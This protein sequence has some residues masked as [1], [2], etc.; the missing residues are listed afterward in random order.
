M[1][2]LMLLLV[3]AMVV[4]GCNG[5]QSVEEL[6]VTGKPEILT[7]N[8]EVP[9]ETPFYP[10]V[11]MSPFKGF[12]A[13]TNASSIA[14]LKNDPK[15]YCF[16]LNKGSI[17]W[18]KSIEFGYHGRLEYSGL[19]DKVFVRLDGKLTCLDLFTGD[20][21]WQSREQIDWI[22]T[23]KDG[24]VFCA[25]NE[26][27]RR[28]DDTYRNLMCFGANDG[29][30]IWSVEVSMNFWSGFY[31]TDEIVYTDWLEDGRNLIVRDTKT[32]VLKKKIQ[33]AELVGRNFDKPTNVLYRLWNDLYMHTPEKETKIFSFGRIDKKI[34]ALASLMSGK[35]LLGVKQGETQIRDINSGKILTTVPEDLVQGKVVE[36]KA[37]FVRGKLLYVYNC[38]TGEMLWYVGTVLCFDDKVLLLRT[39]D[40]SFGFHLMSEYGPISSHEI[41]GEIYQYALLDGFGFVISTK[42][43][44]V[45][46]VKVYK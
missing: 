30:N 4:S 38:N 3:I 18:E 36:D 2:K 42:N 10:K 25:G 17:A 34:P 13:M 1:K 44:K 37:F 32:G 45:V 26:E 43:N 15:L 9:K 16:D 12:V 22:E 33:G 31:G 14:D 21:I 39:S 6:K 27:N 29:S 5:Q 23:A 40:T 41:G 28:N 11:Q 8:L 20:K 24:L 35:L 7:V 19:E 46:F